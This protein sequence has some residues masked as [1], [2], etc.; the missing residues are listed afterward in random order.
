MAGVTEAAIGQGRIRAGDVVSAIPDVPR[1][2]FGSAGLEWIRRRGAKGTRHYFVANRTRQPVSGWFRL[3]TAARG[4]LSLDPMTGA[5]S[6]TA[7]RTGGD[8]SPEVYVTLDPGASI[9]LRTF[10]TRSVRGT[11]S[12]TWRPSGPPVPVAGPWTLR[13]IEGG[14][15][16]PAVRDAVPLGSWTNS[17]DPRAAAFAGTA[18]YTTVFD[19]PRAPEGSWLLDFGVVMDSARVRVNGRDAGTLI[20]PVFRVLAGPLRPRGNVLDVEVTNVAANRIRDLDRRGVAW[21]VFHDINVVNIDYKPFDASGWPVRDAG[22]IG[23]V[24]LVP[25]TAAP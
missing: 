12:P 10:E 11:A 21:R 19:A 22:L 17:N 14:P 9:V 16:L 24:R 1:E 18:A 4:I 5:A 13:F 8:G 7:M 2:R 3:G 6:A 25:V 20:G 15:A 23:P